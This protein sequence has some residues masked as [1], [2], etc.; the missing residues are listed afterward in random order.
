MTEE[1]KTE[2]ATLLDRAEEALIDFGVCTLTDFADPQRVSRITGISPDPSA[3]NNK[4]TQFENGGFPFRWDPQYW[5][6]SWHDRGRE[7]QIHGADEKRVFL[8]LRDAAIKGDSNAQFDLGLLYLLG[9]GV[10]RNF[11]RAERWLK[12]AANKK[13]IPAIFYLSC[14]QILAKTATF[15]TIKKNLLFAAEQNYIPALLALSFIMDDGDEFEE[16]AMQIDQTLFTQLLARS[17]RINA[18]KERERVYDIP[19]SAIF[20]EGMSED[21]I[22][23]YEL[24]H[25][26]IF[27]DSLIRSG[28]LLPVFDTY[29]DLFPSNLYRGKHYRGDKENEDDNFL[30]KGCYITDENELKEIF[31]SF[32]KSAEKEYESAESSISHIRYSLGTFYA[33]GMGTEVNPEQAVYWWEKACE[34]PYAHYLAAGFLSAFYYLRSAYPEDLSKL[35]DTE[36]VSP[37]PEEDMIKAKEW[38]SLSKKWSPEQEIL[39]STKNW[40]QEIPDNDLEE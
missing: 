8:Q 4:Y 16:K 33:I 12:K 13:S 6:T 22:S 7:N 14:V 18:S 30:G 15:D 26:S 1:Q 3:P 32:K 9:F 21:E 17:H 24:W 35:F 38:L 29:S 37:N 19:F 10:K 27:F 5:M 28:K 34:E 39:E 36:V 40:G 31:L 23:S 2:E 25:C 11:Y 20:C